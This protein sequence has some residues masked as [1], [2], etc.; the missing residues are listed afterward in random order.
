MQWDPQAH[1]YYD[2][3]G[4]VHGPNPMQYDY[5]IGPKLQRYCARLQRLWLWTYCSDESEWGIHLSRTE[6]QAQKWKDDCDKRYNEWYEECINSEDPWIPTASYYH[7]LHC[8]ESADQ[9]YTILS[10]EGYFEFPYD[11]SADDDINEYMNQRE[12]KNGIVVKPERLN[13]K[14]ILRDMTTPTFIVDREDYFHK[15]SSPSCI[16][17]KE[18][19]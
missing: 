2:G 3:R 12:H 9:L 1:C 18:L 16:D 14:K 5:Q 10:K 7:T 13:L 6:A 17:Q 8:V 4:V 11:D 15:C 19:F